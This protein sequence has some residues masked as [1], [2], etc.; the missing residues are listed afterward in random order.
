MTATASR[1]IGME[2]T[3]VA[4]G[5]SGTP[6]TIEK[7]SLYF[8]NENPTPS[9]TE[10]VGAGDQA[11][12]GLAHEVPSVETATTTEGEANAPPKVLRKD[13]ATPH[14]AQSTRRGGESLAAMGLEAGYTFTHVAQE[15]SAGA[16]SVSDPDPLS[17]V[18]SPPHSEQDVAQSSKG[19]T[20]EILPQ[21]VD[22]TKVNVQLFMGS[23][24]SGKSTSV[25]SVDGSLGG[26]YQPGWGVTNNCRLDT[27]EAC[28]DMVDHTV[29]PGYFYELHH[30]PNTEFL[31]QYN[32][33][34]ARQVAMGSLRLRFE[35]EVW[36]LK[37]AR[38]KIARRDQRI[39]VREEEIKKLDEE[40]KSLGTMETKVNGLRNRT[41][42]FEMLLEAEVDMKKVAEAKNVNLAKEV[43][44]LSA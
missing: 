1:V 14:P 30:F 7:L 23:P 24:D 6:S 38:A 42:N 33:N 2:D 21:Y 10:R 5:S 35:Q 3:I 32:M 36:L 8:D 31:G 22:T 12:D 29:P 37:E 11:Q 26:I 4:S 34:L 27:P 20:T 44:S 15:T 17:Y 41:Q 43:E 19:T 40:I 16:K 25:S 39:Q 18:R 13:H 28:Q 9:T